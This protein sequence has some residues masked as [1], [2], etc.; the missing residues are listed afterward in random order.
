MTRSFVRTC[1]LLCVSALLLGGCSALGFGKKDGDGGS[2]G[3]SES[4][5]NAQRE[6][7]FG[8]GSIPTAEGEGIFRD[9]H[10][11]YDSHA[12]S[13]MARQDIEYNAQMLQSHSNLRVQLE[14]HCDE[15][16]TAEYN[17][18]LGNK[19]AQA[20]AQVLASLGVGNSRVETISYGEEV[21]LDPGHG[22]AAWSKNRRVHFSAFGAQGSQR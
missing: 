16:G 5:L 13:D 4:D 14:G 2:G 10:F 17:L 9:V 3:L 15:R 7:R 22:E 8:E 12:I 18:A 19:R 11:D 21:P 6:G 20:V 1:S